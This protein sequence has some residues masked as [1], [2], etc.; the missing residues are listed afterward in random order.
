MLSSL[1]VNWWML[2]L[3]GVFAVLFGIL[4]FLWPGLTLTSLVFLFGAYAILDG[5]LGLISG[6]RRRET[7]DRWWLMLLEGLVSIAAGVVAFAYP[8]MTALVLVYVIGVWAI[9]TGVFEIIAAVRL[10]KEIDGE[11]LLGLS[12]LLSILFGVLLF[13]FPGAGALALVWMIAGYAIVFGIL[14]IVLGFRLRGADTSAQQPPLSP[15]SVQS[16]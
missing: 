13:V 7:N 15:S 3:R 8:D 10:R 16:Y 14:M 4:A 2:A 11:W 9:V 6:F 5:I 1:K 12:G